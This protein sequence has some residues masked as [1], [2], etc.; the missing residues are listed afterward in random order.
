MKGK[1]CEGGPMG[2]VSSRIF[3]YFIQKGDDVSRC[4]VRLL[5]STGH[6]GSL[7]KGDGK[8]GFSG[9]ERPA[10]GPSNRRTLRMVLRPAGFLKFH[11]V[12]FSGCGPGF[13]GER[14]FML[15][16]GHNIRLVG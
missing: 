4:L 13:L 8:R 9:L 5:A 7:R 11:L 10:G 14:S 6:I 2:G 15:K 1:E 12:S 3:I 16:L